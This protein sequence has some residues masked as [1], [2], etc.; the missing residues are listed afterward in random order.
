MRLHFWRAEDLAPILDRLGYQQPTVQAP[1]T[2]CR[3]LLTV[4][5]RAYDAR[6]RPRRAYYR[7][8]VRS[9]HLRRSALVT[10]GPLPLLCRPRTV[11]RGSPES[12][13]PCPFAIGEGRSP[14][15]IESVVERNACSTRRALMPHDEG[16]REASTS[17]LSRRCD[18][19]RTSSQRWRSAESGTDGEEATGTGP[20]AKSTI[21]SLD[22]CLVNYLDHSH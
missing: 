14:F 22:R 11:E 21:D 6:H 7:M 9:V 19:R 20:S 16:E 18:A 15:P 4:V 8:H 1:A 10:P 5:L 2:K 13:V 17:A 3:G 12:V